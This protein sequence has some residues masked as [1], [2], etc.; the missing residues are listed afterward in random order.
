[1]DLGPA[2]HSNEHMRRVALIDAWER[3]VAERDALQVA[4]SAAT[5]AA[6]DA[7]KSLVSILA[8]TDVAVLHNS[9]AY[10]VLGTTIYTMSASS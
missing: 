1:M 6:E 9:K 10:F 7:R 4:V 3:S 5:K 2:P 8:N